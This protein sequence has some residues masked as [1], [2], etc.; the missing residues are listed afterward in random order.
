MFFTSKNGAD[1]FQ[2]VCLI[3]KAVWVFCLFFCLE[4]TRRCKVRGCLLHCV[5][6]LE[7]LI[8]LRCQ[9]SPSSYTDSMHLKL[10]FV[11]IVAV[12]IDKLILKFIFMFIW[13]C[14]GARMDKTIFK[15]NKGGGLTLLNF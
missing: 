5:H 8:L 2:Q 13:K 1:C 15:K 4:L 10:K 12:E 14:L 6:G 11:F 9:Y 7:D 3:S